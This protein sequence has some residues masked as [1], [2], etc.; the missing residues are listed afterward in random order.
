MR[1]TR[2]AVAGHRGPAVDKLAQ[3]AIQAQR[4][5]GSWKGAPDYKGFDTPFR[6]TQFAVMALSELY[7]QKRKASHRLP[8]TRTSESRGSFEPE[9]SFEH[10]PL[11]IRQP[12]R[13]PGGPSSPHGKGR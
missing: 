8:R 12:G 13:D 3:Y 5:D 7:P 2:L 9:D 6:D 4:A 10:R 11:A 1:C